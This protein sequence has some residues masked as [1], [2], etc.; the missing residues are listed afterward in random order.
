MCSSLAVGYL[1]R[2]LHHEAIADTWLWYQAGDE[3]IK[4]WK[5]AAHSLE[6]VATLESSSDAVL[7]LTTRD[8]TVF[9]GHQGGVIKVRNLIEYQELPLC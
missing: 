6:H 2:N 7:A 4:L 5:L 9:A 3:D 8:S 1:T